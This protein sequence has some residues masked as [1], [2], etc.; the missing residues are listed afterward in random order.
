MTIDCIEAVD[1]APASARRDIGLHEKI[2]A[3]RS[4][5]TPHSTINVR[6]EPLIDEFYAID[7]LEAHMNNVRHVAV[8][9]FVFDGD[10]LL[11]Q[12]RASTK[13]H[14]AGLWAN[15]VCSHPRWNETAQDCAQ[16]R[17]HEELGWKVPLMPLGTIDYSARVGDLYENEHVHCFHGRFDKLHDIANFNPLEVGA[18]KWLTIPHILQE[19]DSQPQLFSAWFKIYMHKHRQ[20]IEALM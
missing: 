14:S 13:Y 19:M 16:R 18:V 11:L 2:T 17:L 9:V 12:Q 3:I 15:T 6:A 10:R 8:S 20:L 7:K 5:G 4:R 1:R